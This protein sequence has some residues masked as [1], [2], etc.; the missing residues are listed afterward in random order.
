M[1]SL[2]WDLFQAVSQSMKGEEAT[3][4]LDRDGVLGILSATTVNLLREE[5]PA[6]AVHQAFLPV[7]DWTTLVQRRQVLVDR[8]NGQARKAWLEKLSFSSLRSD[9]WD[10]FGI[11][12]RS[13]STVFGLVSTALWLLASFFAAHGAAARGELR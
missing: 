3:L 11:E 1:S 9:V 8:I 12:I 5:L 7:A 2:A 13:G 4:S 6:G 10:V